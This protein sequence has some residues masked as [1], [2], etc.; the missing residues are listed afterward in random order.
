MGYDKGGIT[1]TVLGLTS[2]R[3]RELKDWLF[4]DLRDLVACAPCAP[5]RL[6]SFQGEFGA[7]YIG[8]L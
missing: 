4:L 5:R 2:V 3:S 6:C 8:S 1:I 7:R